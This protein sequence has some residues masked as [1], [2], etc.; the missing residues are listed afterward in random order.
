[1]DDTGSGL[2]TPARHGQNERATALTR[3]N[4]MF[5]RLAD[6]DLQ[7][8]RRQ[9]LNYL[10][11]VITRIVN[12]HP[13]RYRSAPALGLPKPRTQIG[14]G[15]TLT[16]N[17][18]SHSQR[19]ACRLAGLQ[20]NASTRPDDGA[21]RSRNWPRNGGSA[22]GVWGCYWL[23]KSGSITRSFTGSA[24]RSRYRCASAVAASERSISAMS[25]IH[26]RQVSRR[27]PPTSKNSLNAAHLIR[28]NI[29]SRALLALL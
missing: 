12:G 27:G 2:P 14:L 9:S 19:R 5:A 23:G 15:T 1:M 28:Y 6:R 29:T 13:K 17:Q 26:L 18:K 22:T 4:A 10:S 7:D 25:S 3:K 20:P 8:Q 16:I 11:D 24:E 21:V